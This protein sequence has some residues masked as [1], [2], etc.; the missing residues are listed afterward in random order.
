MRRIF[1]KVSYIVNFLFIN[2]IKELQSDFRRYK[3]LK[4][5]FSTLNE[6]NLIKK[7]IVFNVVRC[8][9]REFDGQLF[10]AKFLALNGAKV[11]VLLDDGMLKHWDTTQISHLP[12]IQMIKK[13]PLNPY[14][15]NLRIFFSIRYIYSMIIYNTRL[16]IKKSLKPYKGGNLEFIYYSDII[17]K[18]KISYNNLHELDKHAESS[19]IRFF[20]SSELDINDEYVNYYYNLSLKNALLSLHVGEYILHKINPDIFINPHGTYSTHGPAFE[21]LQQNDIDCFVL[22]GRY[23]HAK[24][25]HVLFLSDTIFQQLSKSKFWLSYKKTQV[26]D[27][28]RKA[29]IDYFESRINANTRDTKI[30]Y[31]GI[32]NEFKVD[33]NDGYKFHIAMFPNVLWDGNVRDR[34]IVFDG[35]IDWLISTIN[36]VKNRS[37]IKLYI[38]AHPAEMIIFI[39]SPKVLDILKSRI[40]FNEINNVILIPPEKKIDTYGFLKS[41]ID[42]GLVYDG[43]LAMEIPYLKIPV[44]MCVKGGFTA[45]E[46]GNFIATHKKGYFNHL[47]NIEKMLSEFHENYNSYFENIVKYLYW[48]LYVQPIKFPLLTRDTN[49]KKELLRLKKRDMIFIKKFLKF[50]IS[51]KSK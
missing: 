31:S 45:I 14:R 48:Y 12:K 30:Y 42:L 39:N 9:R 37:D 6:S 44:L 21:Y 5:Y 35:I 19:T 51:N 43:F 7:T 26:N 3:F 49:Y 18:K 22:L 33:K 11:K 25:P 41:G 27:E 46:G 13:F 17:D 50:L 20:E 1:N 47:D 29:V 34:H 38:K 23:G 24:D 36:Y 16:F 10:L 8:L 28:M 32:R 4:K 15:F 40:D 2:P